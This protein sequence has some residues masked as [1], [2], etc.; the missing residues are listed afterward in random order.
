MP[1]CE[2]LDIQ[3]SENNQQGTEN[4]SQELH[5]DFQL[6]SH[7]GYDLRQDALTLLGLISKWDDHHE[8][9]EG[10]NGIMH[11]EVLYKGKSP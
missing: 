4:R 5:L 3:G 6:H 1:S 2:E 7:R 8:I 9:P 11:M 10:S